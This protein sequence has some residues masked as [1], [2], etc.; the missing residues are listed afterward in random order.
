M[1]EV[2]RARDTR[3]DRDVALKVLPDRFV[4]DKE[5]L[6][7]LEREAKSLAALE[8]PNIAAIHSME[9]YERTRFLVME[10]VPGETLAKRLERGPIPFDEA[11]APPVNR[12]CPH[13]WRIAQPTRYMAS[14]PARGLDYHHGRGGRPFAPLVR[15]A[16]LLCA[17][18]E[19]P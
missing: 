12:R 13:P 4:E 17:A 8:H 5:R 15:S 11:L 18:T 19:I 10:L 6:A 2:W 9:E 7:R 1:G 3:L 16:P 14:P